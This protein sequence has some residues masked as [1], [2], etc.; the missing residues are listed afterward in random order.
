MIIFYCTLFIL[1]LKYIT[2]FKRSRLGFGFL[3]ALFCFKV[4]I[5][6]FYGWINS[7]YYFNGDTKA[8]VEVA[9]TI[10][11]FAEENRDKTV[12]LLFGK[13]NVKPNEELKPFIDKIS[14]WT[15][16]SAYTLVRL[17]GLIGWLTGGYY[18]V[19]VVFWQIFSLV[20]L[21]ALF[22][23]F[24]I[25]FPYN[26]QKLI[27]GIFLMPSVLFWHSGIHKEA[28]SIFS[29]GL[30]TLF[31]VEHKIG[32]RHLWLYAAF[33]FSFVLIF[34]VR[35]YL[36]LLLIPAAIGLYY[37]LRNDPYVWFKFTVIYLSCLVVGLLVGLI[38]PQFNF[39]QTIV[40]IQNFFIVHSIGQSDF[41]IT[42]LEPNLFS[43]IINSPKALF[44]AITKPSFFDI[45]NLHIP[46]K[47]FAAFENSLLILG[48]LLLFAFNRIKQI[49]HWHIIVYCIFLSLS[50]L[51]LIGL[52]VDNI[53][54]LFRYRSVI[55]PLIAPTILLLLNEEKLYNKLKS[56]IKSNN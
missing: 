43:L 6:I 22:K 11:S 37:C 54:A 49:A 51:I 1:A 21:V 19:N 50:F 25:Y 4:I 17:N 12:R 16:T 52:S 2:F 34:F 26:K 15:D 44:N 38:F 39:L 56:L 5:G 53:G 7:N 55:L 13:N 48:G 31:L 3:V 41:A 36:A 46:L 14:Y 35:L 18:N 40:D 8:Y 45:T 47:I 23:A 30:T 20:G 28:I 9:N 32:Y 42:K 29:I 33:A 24:Y 27:I 10:N